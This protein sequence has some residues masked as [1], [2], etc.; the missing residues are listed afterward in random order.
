[1]TRISKTQ[2]LIA[3]GHY[4]EQSVVDIERYCELKC[5]GTVDWIVAAIRNPELKQRMESFV[6]QERSKSTHNEEVPNE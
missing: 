3:A 1:M 2:L 5:W 6:E 4:D